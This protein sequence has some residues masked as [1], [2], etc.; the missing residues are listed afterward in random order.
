MKKWIWLGAIV[1]IVFI[2]SASLFFATPEIAFIP[3]DEEVLN[4]SKKSGMDDRFLQIG[5]QGNN[6]INEE[7]LKLGKK[8]FYEETFGNEVFLTD[9]LGLVDGALSLPNI[10]RAILALNGEGTSNLQVSLSK[11]VQIGERFFKKGTKIDTGIDVAKGSNIPIGMPVKIVNGKPKV[12][13]SCAACHATVDRETKQVIEGAPNSDLNTGLMLALATNST[14]YFTHAQI[15]SIK[16]YITEDSRKVETS[17]G[18]KEELPDPGKLEAA[19]DKIFVNWPRGNFDS[20]IDMKSNPAQI[21]DSF[22][23]GD[24][25]YGWSGFAMAG[26][27]E[28]LSSFSN[29][30]HAQ[31]SDSL[32]QADLSQP[33]F[34]M[35]KEVYLGTILQ[36]AANPKF[37]Y[38]SKETQKPSEFF[39]SVDPTPGSPGINELVKTPQY[40][41]SSVIAPV[42]LVASS[43]GYYFNEQNN[44][45]AAWQ[46]TLVPPKPDRTF[47]STQVERGRDVF[48]RAG[49]ISCHA[50]EAYTNNK[51]IS[52]PTIKTDPSRAKALK[53]TGKIFADSYLYTPST[54]VPVPDDA[55]IVKVPTDHLNKEQVNLAFAHNGSPGGYKVPSLLGLY[56]TA[57]YLHDGGVAVG[58]NIST[59][60]GVAKTLSKGIKVDPANSLR[61]LVD[62][63]LRQ[64]VIQ[65]NKEAEELKELHVKG[66]G[67]EYWVDETTGFTKAQQNALVEYL[68]T[69]R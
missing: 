4:S 22:T 13:L 46:N 16:D 65:A 15:N 39:E 50:G 33:L 57:P 45:M 3:S 31:N 61:A 24:H 64:K 66:I 27:F 53:K 59:Q 7:V 36:N 2:A 47:D 63:N 43:P 52:A 67:H 34:N 55:K 60:L 9:I 56:W 5:Q 69:L 48:I 25:P 40:P 58:E 1:T 14:A 20:T 29:N 68:L 23:L 11:D 21:P 10:T 19:V 35:D 62:K 37:K 8:A 44:A 49:C 18:K 17:S 41:K 42:G 26:P 32:S 38:N 54:S 6:Q 30:V 12:G 28:G 51:I